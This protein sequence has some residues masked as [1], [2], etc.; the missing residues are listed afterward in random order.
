MGVETRAASRNADL[1]DRS[2]DSRPM[3][4]CVTASL[5]CRSLSHPVFKLLRQYYMEFG[6]PDAWKKG[7]R[8][9][10]EVDGRNIS[11][12][13]FETSVVLGIEST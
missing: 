7:P 10:R 13:S 5:S 6:C 8:L 9:S 12:L 2:L 3:P 4:L 11:E 1:E